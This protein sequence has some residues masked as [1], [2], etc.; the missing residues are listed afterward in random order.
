LK[1]RLLPRIQEKSVSCLWGAFRFY[2]LWSMIYDLWSAF[3]TRSGFDVDEKIET[4]QMKGMARW[5][6]PTIIGRLLGRGLSA[7]GVSLLEEPEMWLSLL[8]RPLDPVWEV[9]PT[10]TPS[11]I[12]F[13]YMLSDVVQNTSPHPRAMSSAAVHLYQLLLHA[14]YLLYMRLLWLKGDCFKS[15]RSSSLITTSHSYYTYYGVCPGHLDDIQAMVWYYCYLAAGQGTVC[16]SC[17]H[18]GEKGYFFIPHNLI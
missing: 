17:S 13:G 3:A 10:F 7:L 8:W 1:I 5:T 16:P 18:I 15:M 9:D 12:P 4:E 2:D 11:T 6:N 14:M